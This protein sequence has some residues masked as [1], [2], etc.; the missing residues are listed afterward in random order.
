MGK[1]R[2]PIVARHRCAFPLRNDAARRAG[3]QPPLCLPAGRRAEGALGDAARLW[4][5]GPAGRLEA[6]LRLASRARVAALL[7]HP[8]PLFGGSL[9]NPVVF[10]ADRELNRAGFLTLR[11]NFRGVGSSQG[12]HDEGRGEVDDVAAAAQWLR[13]LAPG[14]PLLLVGY[15]FGASCA[16]RYARREPAAAGIVAIGLPLRYL[17]RGEVGAAPGPLAVVQGGEDEIGPPREVR[18]AIAPLGPLS[19]LYEVPGASHLF[20]G[21][22]GDVAALVV[23]AAGWCLGA[24]ED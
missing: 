1:S 6:A 12:L 18:E 3:T 23:E 20:P 8:H 4:I 21:R 14:L 19:R 10:H 2:R 16:I 22:A 9:H 5:E 13:R 17:S 24:H 11:F 15:S 7:A